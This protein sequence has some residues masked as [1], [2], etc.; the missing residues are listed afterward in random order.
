MKNAIQFAKLHTTI[1]DK[2]LRLVMHCRKSL[3]FFGN[4]IW[5]NNSTESCFDNIMGSFDYTEICKLV[6]LYIQ[7]KLERTLP[8]TNF[9]LYRG[10]GLILLRNFNGHKW[11]KRG[12]LS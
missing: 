6:R 12:K 11:T 1:D 8:K 3:L 9:G 2:V 10:D 4:K 7:S 5:K